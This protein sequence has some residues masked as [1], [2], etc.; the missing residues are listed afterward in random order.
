MKELKVVSGL[1]SLIMTGYSL[2]NCKS[3]EAKGNIPLEPVDILGT[4]TEEIL[5]VLSV[6]PVLPLLP[7]LY[8]PLLCVEKIYI[9]EEGKEEYISN[10]VEGGSVLIPLVEEYYY[11]IPLEI[12]YPEECDC[13]YPLDYMW[14]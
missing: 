9:V 13:L 8:N 11:N 10:C 1:L 3:V 12:E 5:P 2:I 6:L 14:S 7:V 4:Y